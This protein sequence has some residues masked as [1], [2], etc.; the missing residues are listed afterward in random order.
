MLATHRGDYSFYAIADQMVWRPSA[1]SPQS[2]GVFARIMGAPDDRN[3][4]DLGVKAGVTLK[5]PFKGATMTWSDWR[6]DTR[7]LAR[8]HKGSPAIRPRCLRRAIRRA[9]RR[10]SSKL[11]TCIRSRHGGKC[12]R[13]SSTRFARQVAFRIRTTP[14]SASTMKPSS[15]CEPISY[16]ER[17]QW[18]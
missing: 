1:Y 8:M 7:R 11:P 14:P 12:R 9:A 6:S 13:T 3:L 2:V 5:A 10:P 17:S 15:E 18:N 4:V 16:S